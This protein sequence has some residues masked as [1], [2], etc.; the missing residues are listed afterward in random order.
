MVAL[1]RPAIRI[2][3]ISSLGSMRR[4]FG[5]LKIENFWDEVGNFLPEDQI[6]FVISGLDLDH[7]VVWG[8][9]HGILDLEIRAPLFVHYKKVL[10][11]GKSPIRDLSLL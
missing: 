5:L 7:A 9:I 3:P 8:L 2:S 10:I 6:F 11:C 4:F 1:S